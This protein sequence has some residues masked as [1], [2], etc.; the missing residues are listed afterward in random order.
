MTAREWA[1]DPMTAALIFFLIFFAALCIG[2]TAG[3]LYGEHIE[4]KKRKA[5]EEM[6]A[7]TLA[8][9]EWEQA[10]ERNLKARWH[11]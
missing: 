8:H 7:A 10:I 9:I 4:R 6:T 3:V 5:R 1:G 11:G 2:I